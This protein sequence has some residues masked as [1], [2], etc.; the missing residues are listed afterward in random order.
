MSAETPLIWT[1][2]NTAIAE[3]V[4]RSISALMDLDPAPDTPEG[5]LLAALADAA[6]AYELV[7]FPHPAPSE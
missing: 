3:G 7:F 1:T 5:K 4:L 2:E 6:Q